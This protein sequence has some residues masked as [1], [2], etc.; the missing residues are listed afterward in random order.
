MPQPT[1]TELETDYLIIGSGAM[2]MAFADVLIEESD[3]SMI[4]VDQYGK[5]GGH[6]NR[7]YP[8][9]SLHQPSNFYG[10]SSR[11]LSQGLVDKVGLNKGLGDLAT[12]PEILAYFDHV[13][14][15][16]FLP[17]GRVQYFP[18]CTYKDNGEFT[19]KLSGTTYRVKAKKIVDAT[20]LKTSVPSTHK[21]SFTVHP[22][23]RF[24]PLNDIPKIQNPPEGYVVIGGGKTGIDACLYLLEE[25]VAPEDIRWI[26]PRDGW[27]LN[28]KNTQTNPAF[29][30]HTLGAQAGQ[31]E[32]IANA[33]SVEDMFDRLEACGYFLRIDKNIRPKMFHGATISEM[34][35]S[36]LQALIPNIIRM[37]RVQAIEL[38]KIILDDG[39]IT[40][41]DNIIHVDCSA[42]AVM[43]EEMKPIFDGSLITPQMIR[44]YQPV[45]SAAFAAHV[46][47]TR[48]TDVEKNSLCGVVPLP[49]HDTDFIRFT[50]ATMMNQYKWGQ[51]KELRDWLIGNRLDGFSAMVAAVGKDE[52]EKREILSRIRRSAMPAAMKLTQFLADLDA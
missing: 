28:R 51:D 38:H 7:A 47:L 42:R 25:G 41:S 36:A 12:G 40:T 34:E 21:P 13:M 52:T 16:Q 20:H 3:V 30:Q 17:T 8:F 44:S 37:G 4:I 45:F 43:N 19:H 46:E 33:S 1:I 39:V 48:D 14:R 9:V 27:L 50:H 6:W 35:L 32:S 26:M 49:N 15:H 31:F 24:I 2:G 29:F 5:P 11:E 22:K 23:A 18:L 10:V